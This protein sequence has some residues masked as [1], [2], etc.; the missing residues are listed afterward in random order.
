MVGPGTG[1]APFRSILLNRELSSKTFENQLLFFGCRNAK[2]DF[3]CEEDLRR[4][5]NAG[6]IKLFCAFSRDQDDKM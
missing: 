4:L 3:H 6:V 2:N 5:E 1:L